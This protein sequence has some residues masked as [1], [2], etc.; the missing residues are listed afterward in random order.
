MTCL[1]YTGYQVLPSKWKCFL[2]Q[3]WGRGVEVQKT[4][5]TKET[6]KAQDAQKVLGL[7]RLLAK[8]IMSSSSSWGKDLPVQLLYIVQGC[9]GD[10]FTRCHTC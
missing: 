3:A 1:H 2:L 10:A 4:P 9:I 5:E 6:Y 7:P 8:S